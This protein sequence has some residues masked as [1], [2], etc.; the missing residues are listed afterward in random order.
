MTFLR[1][2]THGNL[3]VDYAPLGY[4]SAGRKNQEVLRDNG[5]VITLI[6]RSAPEWPSGD[7][8][9]ASDPQE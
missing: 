3:A 9:A 1:Q 8:R 5:E 7:R 2:W 4:S 6:G